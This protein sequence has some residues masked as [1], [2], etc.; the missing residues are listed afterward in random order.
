MVSYLGHYPEARKKP[1][2]G[3]IRAVKSFI[4]Q[5]LKESELIIVADGCQLTKDLYELHFSEETRIRFFMQPKADGWPGLHRQFGIQQS[6]YDLITYLDSDDAIGPQ[7][8][9]GL[10]SAIG[11]KPYVVDKLY[12]IPVAEFP[13]RKY[14]SIGKTK[15]EEIDF[16][17]FRPTWMGGT[18]QFCHRKIGAQWTNTKVRGEDA[19]FLKSLRSIQLVKDPFIEVGQYFVCHHPKLGWDV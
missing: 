1:I 5:D 13:A 18:Y 7:R 15:F 14:S 10:V 11:Q 19:K 17:I 9:S 8:L 6:R 4:N 3:F 12:T 16:W 2:E